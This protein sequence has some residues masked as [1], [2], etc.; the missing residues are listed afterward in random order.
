MKSLCLTPLQL[1]VQRLDSAVTEFCTPQEVR[2]PVLP[3]ITF[4][5]LGSGG[6]VLPSST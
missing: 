1:R 6:A 5:Q 2:L 3:E 4:L